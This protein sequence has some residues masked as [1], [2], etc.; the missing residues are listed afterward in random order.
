[1]SKPVAKS[2]NKKTKAKEANKS[3]VS[4]H[5]VGVDRGDTTGNKATKGESQKAKETKGLTTTA[6]VFNN[7]AAE[8][9]PEDAAQE[10]EAE[11]EETEE[12]TLDYTDENVVK[13]EKEAQEIAEA[14]ARAEAAKVV[15]A[16]PSKVVASETVKIK[17]TV[18]SLV[19]GAGNY[20]DFIAGKRYTVS[21]EMAAY[22]RSK[23]IAYEK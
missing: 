18:T 11:I 8:E 13:S 6:S 14:E 1:M 23:D 12:E 5:G 15:Q 4:P 22:L 20:Y 17:N 21:T 2:A 9:V 10:E 19:Y 16:T 3:I 7:Q